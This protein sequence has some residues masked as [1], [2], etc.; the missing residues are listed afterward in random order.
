MYKND[1]TRACSIAVYEFYC[2]ERTPESVNLESQV[3]GVHELIVEDSWKRQNLG[4]V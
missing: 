1:K 2:H 3:G 4:I